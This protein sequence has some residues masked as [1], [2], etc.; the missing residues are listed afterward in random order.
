MNDPKPIVPVNPE[1]LDEIAQSL[2][3]KPV[4]EFKTTA[5]PAVGTST[6][7]RDLYNYIILPGKRHG[8]YEYPDLLVPAYMT[9]KARSWYKAPVALH[10]ENAFMLTIRQYVDYRNLLRSGNVYDGRGAK[11]DSGRV[12]AILDEISKGGTEWLDARFSTSGRSLISI[13][14]HKIKSDGTLEEVTEPLGECLMED[15]KIV[16]NI[17]QGISLDNWLHNATNQG[18]P[19]K[20]ISEGKLNYRY[21][22]DKDVAA[23]TS[24]PDKAYLYCN[25][26]PRR[27]FFQ[28]GIRAAKI[29]R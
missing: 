14:Y 29:N 20:N 23:F 4:D 17:Q 2:L 28:L 15:K 13:T 21:P 9:H 19:P 11:L 18:L 12:N 27:W 6:P 25:T 16:P 8:S 24:Y 3:G 26:T 10:R 7:V 22:R 1:G 5:P